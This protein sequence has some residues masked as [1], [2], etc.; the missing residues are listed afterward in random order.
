MNDQATIQQG[1]DP[2]HG[3]REPWNYAEAWEAIAVVQPDRRALMQGEREISWKEFDD[4]ANGLALSLLCGGPRRNAKIAIHL[5][6]CPEYMIAMFAA[7]KLAMAPVNV[8][9]RYG[10][11]EL[12]FLFDNSDAEAVIFDAEFAPLIDAIRDRLPQV[13]QWICVCR[14]GQAAPDWAHDWADA[15]ANPRARAAITP[16]GRSDNDQLILYTGGTTGMPKGVVWRQADLWGVSDYGANPMLGQAALSHPREAAER[17]EAAGRPVALIACPLMHG[18]GLFSAIGTL[19]LGGAA[20]FLP[21]VQFRA[22]E[23]L[24]ELERLRADRTALVG[25]AFG[26]PLLEALDAEPGRWDLS[27]LRMVISSGAMWPQENKQG[28]LRHLPQAMLMD[29]FSSSEAIGMGLSVLTSGGE[30]KTAKFALGESCAV[31]SEDGRRVVPG[32]GEIGRVAVGGYLPLGYYKDAAKT[33]ATFPTYEGRRWSIP[34]DWATVQAN[35]E[36]TLLGRGSE[37][38]NTGGEK[39]FP[40]EVEEVLKRHATVRDAAVLGLPD[41]R[42]GERICA[43]VELNANAAA[44]SAAELASH[45]CDQLAKYKQPRAIFFVDSVARG[46]NGKLD[47]PRLKALAAAMAEAPAAA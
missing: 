25:M 46:P 4:L 8:N 22:E 43:L 14:A 17:V 39:V 6:N 18:T 3:A 5:Y 9:F 24:D 28:L 13:G 2:G 37:C 44:P 35:G 34:G 40:E 45:V 41:T 23:M 42:F 21:S 29:A 1:D 32:S 31:F 30:A 20:A 47:Y 38:I 16:W 36:V 12:L 10:A 11:E 15:T 27:S 26:G 7:F 19:T 33:A